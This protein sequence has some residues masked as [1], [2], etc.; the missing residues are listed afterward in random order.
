[1]SPEELAAVANLTDEQFRGRVSEIA[2]RE[3]DVDGLARFLRIYSAGSGDY[4]RDRHEW[5][6][7]VTVE[8]I[9]HDIQERRETRS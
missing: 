1:M 3:L 4:T 5:L 6:S 8:Q 9:I 2:A 7:G